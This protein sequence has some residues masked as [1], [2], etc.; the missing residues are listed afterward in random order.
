M[1]LTKYK[2]VA[3]VHPKRGG[4]DY[5]IDG[6]VHA[7]DRKEAKELIRKYLAKRSMCPDDFTIEK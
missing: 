2:F 1:K 3:W 4:D 7:L 6:V 5:P